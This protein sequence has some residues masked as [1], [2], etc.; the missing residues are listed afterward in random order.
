MD[1]TSLEKTCDPPAGDFLR[2]EHNSYSVIYIYVNDLPYR[3][4]NTA[5][6]RS[7]EKKS[8]PE[9]RLQ[10]L[11]NGLKR[12]V[13]IPYTRAIHLSKWAASQTITRQTTIQDVPTASWKPRNPLPNPL[14]TCCE[15]CYWF[16]GPFAKLRRATISFVM[17]V[18][19]S[20]W[21]NSAPT[22]W[23]FTKFDI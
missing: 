3:C 14:H 11:F 19:S 16:L 2:Y 23:I 7:M 10:S 6:R 20:V 4:H 9:N 5:L 13:R 1:A 12:T 8:S 21:S 17:S 18:R 15:F 22:G